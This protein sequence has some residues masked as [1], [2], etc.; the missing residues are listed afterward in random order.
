MSGHPLSKYEKTL[1]Q[2]QLSSV[3]GLKTLTDGTVTRIGE[4]P[5]RMV[6]EDSAGA[7]GELTLTFDFRI[8]P[9]LLREP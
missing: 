5:V 3:D 6:V 8:A 1:K 7:R 4:F 9:I 2:Y